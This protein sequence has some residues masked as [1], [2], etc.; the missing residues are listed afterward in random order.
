MI[1]KKEYYIPSSTG[2]DKLHVVEWKPEGEVRGILQISHG[3]REYVARYHRFA[4]YMA[5]KGFFVIGNDH[6]GHGETAAPNNRFGY[7]AAKDGCGHAVRDL[8]RVTVHARKLYPDVPLILLGHSMGSF[9]AR[10]YAMDY[11]EELEGLILL[12]TGG[13]PKGLLALGCMIVRLVGM[14]KSQY[15]NSWLLEQLCFALYNRRISPQRTPF[16]WLS[17][18]EKTVDEFCKDPLC[19]F[20]LTVNGYHTLFESIRYIQKWKHVC[21]TPKR[22]PVLLMSGGEDPVGSYGRSVRAVENTYRRVGLRDVTC[23][24]YAGARHE[25]LNEIDYEKAQQAILEW[26]CERY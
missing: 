16:D 17:R 24:I 4:K 23:R 18:S 26:I 14:V 6:L 13:Q 11:G 9:F 3:M 22:L 21:K 8:R 5:E 15:S 10:R 20:T 19:Q 1:E 2:E 12:G 25:L 7:F